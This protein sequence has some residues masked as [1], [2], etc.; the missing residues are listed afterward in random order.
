MQEYSDDKKIKIEKNN[1]HHRNNHAKDRENALESLSEDNEESKSS[2]EED[3]KDF[4]YYG[5]EDLYYK[6]EKLE[7]KDLDD[8]KK[9]IKNLRLKLLKFFTSLDET[10]NSIINKL[11]PKHI[12]SKKTLN[13]RKSQLDK[14]TEATGI[15]LKD[16]KGVEMENNK[17]EHF[18]ELLEIISQLTELSYFDVYYDTYNKILKDYGEGALIKWKYRI[19]QNDNEILNEYGDFTTSQIKEWHKNVI[20]KLNNFLTLIYFK[21]KEIFC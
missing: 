6:E 18:K 14:N 19:F 17:S 2:E 12:E 13:V 15:K 5:D 11:K 8:I 10:I 1:N 4:Q 21:N 3:N 7:K 20:F 16:N 9:N